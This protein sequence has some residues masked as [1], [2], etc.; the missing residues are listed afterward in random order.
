MTIHP[1][2]LNEKLE[3]L[4]ISSGDLA[5]LLGCS[6]RAVNKWRAGQAGCPRAVGLVL[7]ALQQKRISLPWIKRVTESDK[8]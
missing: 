3:L 2:A 8:L 5:A 4:E 6:S 1:H 7:C